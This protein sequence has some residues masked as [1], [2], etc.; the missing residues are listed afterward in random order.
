MIMISTLL[1]FLLILLTVTSCNSLLA[2][3]PKGRKI[4]IFQSSQQVRRPNLSVR[5]AGITIPSSS[6]AK[7]LLSKLS[8]RINRQLLNPILS[9]GILAGGLH[10]ITG[11][12]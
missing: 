7:W 1:A 5:G 10:A 4:Q 11:T 6:D 3:L 12:I 9:G 2:A 8:L